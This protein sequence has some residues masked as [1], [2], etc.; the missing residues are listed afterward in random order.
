MQSIKIIQI[1]FKTI[2]KQKMMSM[3]IMMIMT[4]KM[5]KKLVIKGLFLQFL[6]L[7]INK[8]EILIRYGMK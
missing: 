6:K 1:F 3:E 2:K 4:M 8:E 7:F 5:K